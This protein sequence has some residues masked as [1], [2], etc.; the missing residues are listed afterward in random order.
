MCSSQR[1]SFSPPR[2]PAFIR[3]HF[4]VQLR[5]TWRASIH[6][7]QV[8]R[9]IWANSQC[10]ALKTQSKPY[11]KYPYCLL[12][13][14]PLALLSRTAVSSRQGLWIAGR[15]PG[16]LGSRAVHYASVPLRERSGRPSPSFLQ[17]FIQSV[18]RARSAGHNS[19]AAVPRVA[20]GQSGVL[21]PSRAFP[22]SVRKFGTALLEHS[23][24]G[25]SWR[26]FVVWEGGCGGCKTRAAD[27]RRAEGRYL[28]GVSLHACQCW[29][30]GLWGVR[31]TLRK[32]QL[33]PM[34]W[35]HSQVAKEETR[36]KNLN[37]C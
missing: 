14:T 33:V 29:L 4:P 36:Q 3:E 19:V 6:A 27:R 2:A 20:E 18:L 30:C 34:A 8:R 5:K 22:F 37:F 13:S 28:S 31:V 17:C 23:G 21:A 9:F 16:S 10:T 32:A 15:L 1:L 26:V 12:G 7:G 25:G 11:H 24:F 35:P